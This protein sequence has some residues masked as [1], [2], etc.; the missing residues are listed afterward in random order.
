MASQTT[1][2][3]VYQGQT[4][5]AAH[6]DVPAGTA[7]NKC[8]IAAAIQHEDHLMT[9]GHRIANTGFQRAREDPTISAPQFLPHI[10]KFHA[11]KRS[12]SHPFR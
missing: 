5:A 8:E 9:G 11:G 4:A 6:H 12:V 3:M 1:V 10:D 2:S 7:H